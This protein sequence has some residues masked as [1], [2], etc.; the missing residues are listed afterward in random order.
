MARYGQN[1][2]GNGRS[3]V[4]VRRWRVMCHTE[5]K[6]LPHTRHIVAGFGPSVSEGMADNVDDRDA[7]T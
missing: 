5:W 3:P 1:G 7:E 2:H 4:W 6:V